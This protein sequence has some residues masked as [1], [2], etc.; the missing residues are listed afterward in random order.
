MGDE[1]K[2]DM[3]WIVCPSCFR[4]EPIPEIFDDSD[5]EDNSAFDYKI[6]EIRLFVHKSTPMVDINCPGRNDI[7]K[8]KMSVEEKEKNRFH[9]KTYYLGEYVDFL[10]KLDEKLN[11]HKRS[12]KIEK[13]SRGY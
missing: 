6:H 1:D 12:S 8:S 10:R 11:P 13:K 2:S 9:Y 3:K 4:S 5:E 7:D